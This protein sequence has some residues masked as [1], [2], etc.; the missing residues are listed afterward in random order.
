[1]PAEWEK[2]DRCWML[3]VPSKSDVWNEYTSKL[4]KEEFAN[5]AKAISK[6]EVCINNFYYIY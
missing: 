3:W 2:H 5:V 6:Y 4:V 1:M